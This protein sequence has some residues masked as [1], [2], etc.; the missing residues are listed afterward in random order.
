M[1]HLAPD[2]R[3]SAAQVR[4]LDAKRV[5]S[6]LRTAASPPECVSRAVAAVLCALG[7]RPEAGSG[8]AAVR[9]HV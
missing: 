7:R 8:W 1:D 9:L 2:V 6:E 3:R 4:G 5:L